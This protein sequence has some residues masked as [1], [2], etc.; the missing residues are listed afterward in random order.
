[1]GLSLKLI[2]R[3]SIVAASA[4]AMLPMGGTADTVTESAAPA[5]VTTDTPEYCK[6]LAWLYGLVQHASSDN[7]ALARDG[8][9]M[10]EQGRVRMGVRA[11][12]R[13]LAG[14]HAQP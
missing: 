2:A 4:V 9:A 11:L 5:Q 10:C 6:H 7:D 14:V 13:A 8:T 1:M 3:S 12:R